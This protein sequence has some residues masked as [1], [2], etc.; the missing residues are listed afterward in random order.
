[1]FCIGCL[2]GGVYELEYH[3]P[4]AAGP[5]LALFTSKRKKARRSVVRRSSYLPQRLRKISEYIF[6]AE[7]KIQQ[8]LFDRDR[9]LLYVLHDTPTTIRVFYVPIPRNGDDNAEIQEACEMHQDYLS[10]HYQNIQY[11]KS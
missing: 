3:P 8:M 9:R 1:M 2:D 5:F 7:G 10:R 4:A 6:G 11:K